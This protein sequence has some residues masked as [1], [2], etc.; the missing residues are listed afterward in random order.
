M[1]E[2]L[3]VSVGICAYNEQANI[4]DL[5][6]SLQ[7]QK[8]NKVKIIQIVVVSSASTD[9]TD[10]IV[11]GF[12]R[13]D[14]R[15]HLVREGERRGKSSAVN[16]FLRAAAGDVCVL[17]SA[18]TILPNNSIECLCL[19]FLDQEVGMTGG[20]PVPVNDPATFMGFV[21]HL[22]WRLAHELSLVS[23]KLGEFIAFR[24]IIDSIPEQ[25]AV[26]EASIEAKVKEKGY[27]LQYVPEALVYN[28]GPENISD[29]LRQ[30]RR[31]YAGHLH[32]RRSTGYEVSS[33]S[34]LKLLRLLIGCVEPTW[35]SI[36]W[37]PAAVLLEFYSRLLGLYDFYVVK[38]NPY[39]WDIARSTKALRQH[40]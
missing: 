35:R 29:Y 16:L 40:D 26:D 25:S 4:G 37:T 7:L 27:R 15:I 10:E 36:L 39:I 2:V 33:M 23:P 20:R 24:N 34:S 18:D 11:E 19:P 12:S 3:S 31:I 22:I 32:L 9:R 5:L 13:A 1:K 38:R 21:D 30:R 8:T 14:R 17:V 6:T 28:K